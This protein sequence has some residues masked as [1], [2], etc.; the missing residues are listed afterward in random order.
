MKSPGMKKYFLTL[1]IC[2]IFFCTGMAQAPELK[3]KRTAAL[4]IENQIKIDGNLSEVEWLTAENA[5]H[6]IQNTPNPGVAP[7]E[8]T[9][10][11]GS[12]EMT[13]RAHQVL[14]GAVLFKASPNGV[15]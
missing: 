2:A 15:R 11:K 1:A 14:P 8:K 10:E 9:I 7:T 6:F 4:R 12:K 5:E 13:D 3:T